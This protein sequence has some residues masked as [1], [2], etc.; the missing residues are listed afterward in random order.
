MFV[1]TTKTRQRNR[2]TSVKLKNRR[3]GEVLTAGGMSFV[4]SC[5]LKSRGIEADA[6]ATRMESKGHKTLKSCRYEL[7]KITIPEQ[8]RRMARDVENA[9]IMS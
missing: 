5:R 7:K 3:S 4:P 8:A 9:R 2:K 6:E 1:G